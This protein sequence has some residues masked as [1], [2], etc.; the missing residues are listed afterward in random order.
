MQRLANKSQSDLY[1]SSGRNGLKTSGMDLYDPYFDYVSLLLKMDGSNDSTTFKDS[2]LKNFSITTNGDAK[3][4]TAQSKFGGSS[5]IFDGTGDY[6]SLTATNAFNFFN[7]N[8]TV[9]C[10][11]YRTVNQ[12][13][14]QLFGDRITAVY[15]SYALEINS[16][17]KLHLHIR[18]AAS[19]WYNTSGYVSNT[20]IAANQWVHIAWVCNG[21]KTT[22][23]IDGVADSVINNLNIPILSAYAQPTT[24]YVGAGGNGGINGYI[25]D[26]RVTR[27]VARYTSNFTPPTVVFPIQ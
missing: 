4:S 15:S 7:T 2:S 14:G 5:A 26:L 8:Y 21:S 16:S 17:N 24:I 27:G 19:S 13:G 23:Y 20:V 9:E 6:L 3:V 12:T 25:D 1:F 18:S 11:F 22:M 10:W